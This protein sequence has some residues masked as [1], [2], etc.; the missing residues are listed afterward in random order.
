MKF[1][2]FAYEV[3]SLIHLTRA[4]IDHLIVNSTAHYDGRCKEASKPGPEGFLWG[5]HNRMTYEEEKTIEVY[6]SWRQVDCICKIL[7]SEQRVSSGLRLYETFRD[8]LQK[9]SAEQRKIN[10]LPEKF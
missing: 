2:K 9:M 7:E 10:D 5:F 1:E 6:V 4:E 3:E 8:L